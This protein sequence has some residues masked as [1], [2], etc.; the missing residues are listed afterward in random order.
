MKTRFRGIT[1]V[2]RR[3]INDGVIKGRISYNQVRSLLP[4]AKKM[5]PDKVIRIS[6]YGMARRNE[7]QKVY[8]DYY[9]KD[10]QLTSYVKKPEKSNKLAMVYDKIEITKPPHETKPPHDTK[11]KEVCVLG[12]LINTQMVGGRMIAN[13]EVTSLDFK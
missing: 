3:G 6:L 1:N 11:K 10:T 5:A 7:I 9:T 4:E 12:K 2:V 8:K 13:V